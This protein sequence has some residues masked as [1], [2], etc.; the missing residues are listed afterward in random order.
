MLGLLEWLDKTTVKVGGRDI[1]N[2]AFLLAHLNFED[3]AE[4]QQAVR[5]FGS[6]LT[7][8][9]GKRLLT[10]T[11]CGGSGHHAESTAKK[12]LAHVA[13]LESGMKT[14]VMKVIKEGLTSDLKMVTKAKQ[15]VKGLFGR[16]KRRT[17]C[18]YLQDGLK[19]Q[20]LSGMKKRIF[21]HFQ[22]AFNDW[23]SRVTWATRA[24]VA[25]ELL[26]K[27]NKYQERRLTAAYRFVSEPLLYFATDY[28]Q[29]MSAEEREALLILDAGAGGRAVAAARMRMEEI[30]VA[31]RDIYDAVKAFDD[32]DCHFC[33]G[34]GHHADDCIA[35]AHWNLGQGNHGILGKPGVGKLT[36][37]LFNMVG[38]LK[39]GRHQAFEELMVPENLAKL[40]GSG[41][42]D[43]LPPSRP[44]AGD[45]RGDPPGDDNHGDARQR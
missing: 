17:R 1:K 43:C 39:A 26:M 9:R 31:Q 20:S 32:K 3:E 2:L 37:I 4:R 34:S 21:C 24:A 35:L 15:A 42:D 27:G 6:L 8:A 23:R 45:G 29:A 41:A 44:G 28:Q 19:V 22:R 13:L 14:S 30:K 40:N 38:M 5:A 12:G 7:W 25:G 18:S 36:R 10:C 33:D 16:G 11:G